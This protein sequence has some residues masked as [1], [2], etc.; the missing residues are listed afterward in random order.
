MLLRG[1]LGTIGFID[2]VLR[3]ILQRAIS[4]I[5]RLH[6][7]SVQLGI[8]WKVSLLL[9]GLLDGWKWGAWRLPTPPITEICRSSND[10]KNYDSAYYP[11][12]YSARITVLR[13]A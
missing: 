8:V 4:F 11:S 6:L 10:S 9:D 3:V 13:L 5:D 1:I 12:S 7:M 2:L